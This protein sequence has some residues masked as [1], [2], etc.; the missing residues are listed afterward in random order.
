MTNVDLEL[1][2]DPDMYLFVEEG[3]RGGISMISNRYSKAN[4][5]Y[6]P[7]Y[8]PTKESSYVVYLDANILYGWAM[9]QPMP[10]GEFEWLSEHEISTFNVSEIPND[11]ETG[12]ILDV[13]LSYPPELHHLHNDY[14]LAPEKM[15]IQSE[16]LSPYCQQ[17]SKDLELRNASVSKLVPNL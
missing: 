6:V 5:P 13:D 10:T 17:L 4:N 15:K 16:M 1:L 8:D 14:P 3:L 12:Y 2:T 11:S 7:D 9:S